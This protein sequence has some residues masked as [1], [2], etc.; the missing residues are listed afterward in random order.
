MGINFMQLNKTQIKFVKDKYNKYLELEK[1]QVALY[2]ETKKFLNLTNHS[3][4]DDDLWEHFFIKEEFEKGDLIF[5][6]DG[7][8]CHPCD[9]GCICDY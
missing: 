4:Q 3:T 5:L 2:E 8:E 6:S 1:Q 9:N 7:E